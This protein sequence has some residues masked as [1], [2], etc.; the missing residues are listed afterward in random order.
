MEIKKGIQVKVI[1]GK[2]KGKSG[3]ILQ[4]KSNERSKPLF[5][6]FSNYFHVESHTIPK[7]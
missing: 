3:Q 7:F 4:I 1:V 5:T 2:D 6:K